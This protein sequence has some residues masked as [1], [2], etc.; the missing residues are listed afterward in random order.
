[1]ELVAN[2]QQ[3]IIC[4][5]SVRMKAI[6]SQDLTMPLMSPLPSAVRNLIKFRPT[7]MRAK[8]SPIIIGHQ[9]SRASPK[10]S[11]NLAAIIESF[12][13]FH[14]P[15]CHYHLSCSLAR[16][17]C[18]VSHFGFRSVIY[19]RQDHPQYSAFVGPCSLFSRERSSVVVDDVDDCS[20]SQ[21]HYL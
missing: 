6:C 19:A 2:T 12:R 14:Q 1:M 15:V 13:Q 8:N 11:S 17:G 18:F 5:I 16:A 3:M 7:V 4:D 10:E 9:C 21:L 20:L